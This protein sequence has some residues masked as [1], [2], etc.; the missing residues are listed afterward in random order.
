MV[1]SLFGRHLVNWCYIWYKLFVSTGLNIRMPYGLA[2]ICCFYTYLSCFYH[3]QK[4]SIRFAFFDLE[5]DLGCNNDFVG[6]YDGRTG[7]LV[8]KMCGTGCK[9]TK[10][11]TPSNKVK[12]LFRSN[13]DIAGRGFVLKFRRAKRCRSN[14][15]LTLAHLLIVQWNIWHNKSSFM[16]H[17][18]I[19]CN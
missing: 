10:I 9:G 7:Q 3:A 4:A 15:F 18:Y 16:K 2:R 19:D 6:I 1:C 8:S 17:K 5:Y 13:D 12:I 11:V 14:R